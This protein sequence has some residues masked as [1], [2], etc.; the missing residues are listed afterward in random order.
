VLK[1]PS[2]RPILGRYVPPPHANK[3]STSN[4]L[5]EPKVHYDQHRLRDEVDDKVGREEPCTEEVVKSAQSLQATAAASSTRY[6]H[7]LSLQRFRCGP[8]TLGN[9]VQALPWSLSLIP[10]NYGD[11]S[12]PSAPGQSEYMAI[13]E[14][15][16]HC[17]TRSVQR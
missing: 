8:Y 5:S 3:A 13:Q 9:H 7:R 2:A 6:F 10:S 12:S 15:L 4:V 11:L 1:S 14:H 17:S 16:W